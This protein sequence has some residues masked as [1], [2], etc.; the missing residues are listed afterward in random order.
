MQNTTRTYLP[1]PFSTPLVIKALLGGF[2]LG[3][4]KIVKVALDENG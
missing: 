1:P 2:F 4:S 3:M